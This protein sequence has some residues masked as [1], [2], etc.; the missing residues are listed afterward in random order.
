MRQVCRSETG[1]RADLLHALAE[2]DVAEWPENDHDEDQRVRLEM[3][4][5]RRLHAL[6]V[7]LATSTGVRGCMGT[8]TSTFFWTPLRA[9][10][11]RS[12]RSFR[13]STASWNNRLRSFE[14]QRES[15][16]MRH[17]TRGRK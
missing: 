14:S 11:R 1:N 15:R 4:A 9:T 13:K 6:C 17:A 3:Q 12:A 10:F 2:Q 7:S 16:T 8:L 5:R